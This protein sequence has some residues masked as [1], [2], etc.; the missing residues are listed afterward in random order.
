MVP[1]NSTVYDVTFRS[2][3]GTHVAAPWDGVEHGSHLEDIP[4]QNRPPARALLVH[5]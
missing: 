2:H 1:P 3:A 5:E 4:P